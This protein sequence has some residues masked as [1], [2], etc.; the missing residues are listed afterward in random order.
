MD[1]P[2]EDA[3][4]IKFYAA[5]LTPERIVD[6]PSAKAAGTTRATRDLLTLTQRGAFR[7]VDGVSYTSATTARTWDC[8]I[9]GS[10]LTTTASVLAGYAAEATAMVATGGKTQELA[11]AWLA[12][13]TGEFGRQL[14][15]FSRLKRS[16]IAE[17]VKAVAAGRD[18]TGAFY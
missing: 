13:A 16:A 6:V 1:G 9:L 10:G 18:A 12:S 11:G 15:I 14:K 7:P 2:L 8:S 5:A 4:T 3:G 17:Q